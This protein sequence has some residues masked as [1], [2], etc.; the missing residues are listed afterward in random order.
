VKRE[1]V[2]VLNWSNAPQTVSVRLKRRSRITDF[3]SGAALGT[4]AGSFELKDMP[5]R[6][7][8]LLILE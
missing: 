2:S 6:S 4:H 8:R 1:I 5:G 7:D 3:W